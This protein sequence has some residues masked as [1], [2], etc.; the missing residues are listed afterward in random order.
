MR[1]QAIDQG[2]INDLETTLRKTLVTDI[3][4]GFQRYLVNFFSDKSLAI[5]DREDLLLK[6]YV[7]MQEHFKNVKECIDLYSQNSTHDSATSMF[8]SKI[9]ALEGM[10]E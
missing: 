7:T 6:L 9:A 1:E 3:N 2:N 10:L 4:G 5:E 8:Y